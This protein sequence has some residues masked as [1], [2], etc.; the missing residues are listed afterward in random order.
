MG[1][2]AWFI[3]SKL[4]ILEQCT[5]V[6]AGFNVTGPNLLWKCQRLPSATSVIRQEKQ[7]K[8]EVFLSDCNTE[9]WLQS[10]SYFKFKD[11]VLNPLPTRSHFLMSKIVY[12]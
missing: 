10:T 4:H 5:D 3:V 9:N 2:N 7:E 11:T 12:L 8:D 6:K 1:N